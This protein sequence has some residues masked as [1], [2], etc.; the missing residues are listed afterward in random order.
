MSLKTFQ[1]LAWTR[2][3]FWIVLCIKFFFLIRLIFRDEF[4]LLIYHETLSTDLIYFYTMLLYLMMFHDMI[5]LI[6]LFIFNNY[7]YKYLEKMHEEEMSKILVY[8]KG[9]TEQERLCLAQITA[10]WLASGQIPATTL[11]TLVNVILISI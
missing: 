5:I 10:L 2:K 9:F 3:A 6:F 7:R 1:Y 8:L 11:R 4:F